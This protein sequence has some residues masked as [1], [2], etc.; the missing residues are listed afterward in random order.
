MFALLDIECERMLQAKL[1]HRHGHA[2]HERLVELNA[3][4]TKVLAQLAEA[5]PARGLNGAVQP[6]EV[7][8]V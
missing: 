6:A 8:P 5:Y 3:K 7:V 1:I 2:A 4:R